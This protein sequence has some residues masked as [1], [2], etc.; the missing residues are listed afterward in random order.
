MYCFGRKCTRAKA[1]KELT[2]N[3][4]QKI[5]ILRP[6]P[7]HCFAWQHSLLNVVRTSALQNRSARPTDPWSVAPSRIQPVT[8]SGDQ[9]FRCF[10]VFLVFGLPNQLL[11]LTSAHLNRWTRICRT[12]SNF[13]ARNLTCFSCLFPTWRIQL[14]HELFLLYPNSELFNHSLFLHQRLSPIFMYRSHLL[15]CP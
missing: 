6:R 15:E 8:K 7:I 3:Q 1:T 2:Q 11:F 10:Y 12:H 13:S 9:C 4:N 5:W 14:L